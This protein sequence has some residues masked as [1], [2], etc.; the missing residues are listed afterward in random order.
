MGEQSKVNEDINQALI[1]TDSARGILTFCEWSD[2]EFDVTNAVTALHR[3]ARAPD[4]R[5]YSKDPRWPSV[6]GKAHQMIYHACTDEDAWPRLSK[7]YLL[8]AAWA[9]SALYHRDEALMQCICDEVFKNSKDLHPGDLANLCRALAIMK[10]QNETVM[11]R[12]L[13]EARARIGQFRPPNLSLLS[14]SLATLALKDVDMMNLIAKECMSKLRLFGAKHV[15]D[16]AWAF[17]TLGIKNDKLN[18]ALTDATISRIEEFQTREL[19]SITY[20]LANLGVASE[21][22]MEVIAEKLTM[23]VQDL[24]PSSLEKVAWSF[25]AVGFS[26]EALMSCLESEVLNRLEEF[27]CQNIAVIAWAFAMLGVSEELL[28]DAM[29]TFIQARMDDFKAMDFARIIP[30]FVKWGCTEDVEGELYMAAMK[31]MSKFGP[32]DLVSVAA[33]YEEFGDKDILGQFLE[34]AAY[35]FAMVSEAATGKQWVTFATTV[36]THADKSTQSSFEPKFLAA[37][38]RPLLQRLRAAS[39]P[40]SGSERWTDAMRALQD[41]VQRTEVEDLGPI[42]TRQVLLGQYIPVLS[43]PIADIPDLHAVAEVDSLVGAAWE[44]QWRRNWWVE[45]YAR[46]F[47][48]GVPRIGG[49]FLPPLAGHKAGAGRHALLHAAS[50]VMKKCPEEKLGEV[51]GTLRVVATKVLG[52]DQLAALCQFRHFFHSVRLEVD[53]F[54][55]QVS[56]A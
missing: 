11:Q 19:V 31:R 35:R 20:A 47:A 56:S 45:P 29:R 48:D 38:L 39:R 5:C 16:L 26:D 41:F 25:A 36:A 43:C 1:S 44:L 30:A 40:P 53:Y 46:L 13:V 4:R 51:Q 52:V 9:F 24:D 12:I 3:L 17:S 28:V 2:A 27:S 6:I 23:R 18:G 32:A 54:L 34:G 33:A 37:F 42:Y 50:V 14:W 22:V 55:P 7:E 15:S 21:A 49:K 8:N 10:I